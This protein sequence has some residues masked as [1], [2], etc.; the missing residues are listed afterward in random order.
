MLRCLEGGLAHS[1]L[2]GQGST[3]MVLC[4]EKAK[5]HRYF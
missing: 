5:N 1:H 2:L 3:L 4:L